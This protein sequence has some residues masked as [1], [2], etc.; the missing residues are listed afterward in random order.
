M[1]IRSATVERLAFRHYSFRSAWELPWA[2]AEVYAVLQDTGRYSEWW[3]C[4]TRSDVT[5]DGA[6]EFALR[7]KLPFTLK[8]TLTREQESPRD[9]VLAAAV[10]GDIR[11]QISWNVKPVGDDSALVD[12]RQDVALEK[13]IIGLVHP[14]LR[15]ILRWNHAAAMNEGERGLN[16][17]LA[18]LYPR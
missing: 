10:D 2:Q 14:L 17:R 7:S 5:A 12:F 18:A 15:P 6:G 1:P 11:G 3:S 4:F 16:R 9:G 8:F 13:K